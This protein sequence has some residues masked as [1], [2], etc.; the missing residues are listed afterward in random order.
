MRKKNSELDENGG[1]NE[2]GLLDDDVRGWRITDRL[3]CVGSR[4]RRQNRAKQK[5][6]TFGADPEIDTGNVEEGV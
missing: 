5:S 6:G 3:I 4:R 1:Q 2:A